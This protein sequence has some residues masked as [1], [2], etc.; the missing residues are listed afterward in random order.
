M[1][2][3]HSELTFCVLLHCLPMNSL[4]LLRRKSV[5]FISPALVYETLLIFIALVESLEVFPASATPFLNYLW[6]STFQ[7]ACCKTFTIFLYTY[8]DINECLT[9]NGGCHHNC[10]DSDGSY[11]CSCYNGYQ[12]N[13]DG[14]TCEGR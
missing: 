13:S 4:W 8:S 9:N 7:L 5:N 3:G 2:D 11:S 12:L 6:L 14:H 10:N 1:I